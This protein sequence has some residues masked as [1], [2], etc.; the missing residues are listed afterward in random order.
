[1]WSNPLLTSLDGLERLTTVSGDLYLQNNDVLTSLEGLR[2]L[3]SVG[4]DLDIAFGMM[5]DLTGLENLREVGGS[6]AVTDVPSLSSLEGLQALTSVGWVFGVA[7]CHAL[8]NLT[9]PVVLDSVGALLIGDNDG[10]AST[11]GLQSL[12]IV[13]G[14]VGYGIYTTQNP[15]L[16]DV[17]GYSGIISVGGPIQLDDNPLLRDLDGLRNVTSAHA[18]T[19]ERNQTMTDLRGLEQLTQA[20]IYLEGNTALTSLDGPDNV[21]TLDTLTLLGNANLADISAVSNVTGT[22]QVLWLDGNALTTLAPLAG[23]T[24]VPFAFHI[25]NEDQLVDLNGLHNLETVDNVFVRYNDRLAD[26]TALN[27]LTDVG[28]VADIRFNPL[29]CTDEVDAILADATTATPSVYTWPNGPCP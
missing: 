24:S 11:D 16:A 19:M 12:T 28:T 20:G 4:E 13:T 2:A 7:R 26:I 8:V 22:L 10:L 14:A 18:V 1:M 29:L 25:D 27:A 21:T 6:F 3:E 15:M 17:E 9:G 23:V 5:A